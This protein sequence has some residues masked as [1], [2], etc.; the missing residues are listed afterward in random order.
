M[1]NEDNMAKE[2]DDILEKDLAKPLKPLGLRPV[3]SKAVTLMEQ[4]D[5]HEK[6]GHELRE[7][8][9]KEKLKIL[10]DH[11]HQWSQIKH[12]YAQRISEAVA[13]LESEREDELRKLVEAYQQRIR[14]VDLLTQR[15]DV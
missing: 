5:M 8:L 1:I 13:K 14:E 7:R 2:F 3:E 11:D 4:W 9:R 6:I 12:D 10:A 15:M